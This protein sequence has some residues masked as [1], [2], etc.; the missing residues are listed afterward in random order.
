M[1]S[2]IEEYVALLRIDNV[3]LN[4]VYVK[5]PK[6]MTFKKKLVKLTVMTDTWTEK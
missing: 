1:T 6:L 5:E 3:Q 2:I 4:K